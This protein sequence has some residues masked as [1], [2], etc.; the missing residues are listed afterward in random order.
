MVNSNE[1]LNTTFTALFKDPVNAEKAYNLAVQKGYKK[2]DINILMSEET[3][4]KN[5]GTPIGDMEENNVLGHKLMEGAGVGGAIGTTTGAIAGAIA[6]IGTTLVLPGLGLV[7]A[8]PIAVGLAGAGAGGI[9]GGVLGALV[10]AGYPE[11]HAKDY[12]KALT[13]GGI[14]ISITSHSKDV[15]LALENEWKSYGGENFLHKQ[16]ENT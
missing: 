9:A 13:E 5:Y 8:G 2:E 7:I 6:A 10:N 15:D 3:K 16:A 4:R 12:E 14:V 11:T 1:K